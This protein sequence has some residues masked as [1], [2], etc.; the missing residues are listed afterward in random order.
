MNLGQLIGEQQLRIWQLEEQLATGKVSARIAM[1]IGRRIREVIGAAASPLSIDEVAR[2][3]PEFSARKVRA[4]M[5]VMAAQRR[6]VRVG[7][8]FDARYRLP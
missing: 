4:N 5:Q 3:L 1:G 8:G 7:A 6:L 2:A